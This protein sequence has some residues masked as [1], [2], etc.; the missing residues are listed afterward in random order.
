MKRTKTTTT[1]LTLSKQ[2]L[3]NLSS[4]RKMTAEELKAVAGGHQKTDDFAY[5]SGLQ[6]QQ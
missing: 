5:C 6:W 1:K 2:T 4:A 3:R